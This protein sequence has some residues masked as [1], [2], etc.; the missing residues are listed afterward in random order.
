MTNVIS[1]IPKSVG[2]IRS[3][4]FTIY[5]HINP[6]QLLRRCSQAAS[7]TGA[8]TPPRRLAAL[9]CIFSPPGRDHPVFRPIVQG[10]HTRGLELAGAI[11]NA[12]RAR[13]PLRHGVMAPPQDTIE[14]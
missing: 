3:M 8:T 11:R 1:R 2:I 6:T 14:R 10:C 4:R 12:V 7:P 5:D 9:L 13:K